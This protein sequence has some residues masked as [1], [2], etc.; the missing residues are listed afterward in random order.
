MFVVMV[1]EA[2]GLGGAI[3]A[4]DVSQPYSVIVVTP[5]VVHQLASGPQ[6]DFIPPIQVDSEPFYCQWIERDH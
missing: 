1:V 4:H 3:D 6:V 2:I 5:L